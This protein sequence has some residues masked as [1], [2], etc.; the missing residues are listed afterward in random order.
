ML[1]YDYLARPMK[2]VPRTLEAMPTVTDDGATFVFR[3][4]RG[5]RLSSPTRHSG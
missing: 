4:K 2:L 1:D 5:I 3:F